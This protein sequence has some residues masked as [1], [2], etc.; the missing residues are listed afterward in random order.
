MSVLKCVH[1]IA[2]FLV[3]VVWIANAQSLN[4]EKDSSSI[5]TSIPEVESVLENSAADDANESTVLDNL[6]LYKM[7]ELDID[8]ASFNEIKQIP[9]L[10]PFDA[11]KIILLRDSV[12]H[13]SKKEFSIIEG[14][15]E[16]KEI[17]K[18]F[19]GTHLVSDG[20]ESKENLLDDTKLFFR[21][22]IA[23]DLQ[24]ESGF[25]DSSFEGSRPEQYER[26]LMVNRF[27]ESGILFVKDPGESVSNGFLSGSFSIHNIDRTENFIAGNFTIHSG[28]GL[29]LGR[30]SPLS[31]GGDAIVGVKN[32]GEEL[33]PYFSADEFHYL[34]GIAASAN[35]GRVSASF[36]YSKRRL[37]ATT[38]TD[39][40]ITSFYTSGLYQTETEIVKQN[41][42]QEESFGGNI[43]ERIGETA[44]AGISVVEGLYNKD[45]LISPPY[46]LDGNKFHSVGIHMDIVSNDLNI[47]AEGASSL[48]GSSSE[49]AGVIMKA[50]HSFTISTLVR[51]YGNNYNDPFSSGFGERGV[52]NGENGFYFGAELHPS[53]RLKLSGYY[54]EFALTSSS[55][56]PL[57]GHEF[58]FRCEFPFSKKIVAAVQ[59]KEKIKELEDSE[60]NQEL[61][62]AEVIDSRRQQSLRVTLS[63]KITKAWTFRQRF[64]LTRISYII[65]N[66]AETG[67]AMFGE[68]LFHPSQSRL[69]SIVR[70]EFYDSNSYD[71]RLYEYE[72]DLEGVYSDPPL[73]GKGI[74]WYVAGSFQVTNNIEF[75]CKYS[76]TVK[77]GV[78]NLG[79]GDDEVQGNF[80]NRIAVQLDARF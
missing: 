50:S 36:F 22:R 8:A 13:I 4:D 71:S 58:V 2:L 40:A 42:V 62:S 45:L 57:D 17:L 65:S 27:V 21:S 33:L 61:Q 41:I 59:V 15:D 38:N 34:Q 70:M 23:A 79:S 72:S 47:F 77:Q 80:D 28:E 19:I 64:E 32:K 49:L 51:S 48:N 37:P 76:E 60:P 44:M 26:F 46:D 5:D 78:Q 63:N 74:R 35:S 53:Q 9:F 55:L 66:D 25:A 56:F 16:Q 14:S 6:E 24:E 73:Y 20:G 30:F 3:L 67:M 10:S 11:R 31:K 12:H 69:T 29:V 43:D 1:V 68:A 7:R 52:V 39:G 75:S 18:P 54:D